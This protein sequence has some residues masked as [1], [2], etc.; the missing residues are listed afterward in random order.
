MMTFSLLMNSP[1]NGDKNGRKGSLKFH[2][3]IVH[4]ERFSECS[5]DDYSCDLASLFGCN[6][7]ESDQ[8][9]FIHGRG[10]N[11][12]ISYLSVSSGSKPCFHFCDVELE[13]T[14]EVE[15]PDGS[16]EVEG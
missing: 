11:G 9:E 14:H 7:V 1:E 8:G 2:E 15:C 3:H 4:H 16:Q 13:S 6:G 10:R 12:F 5:F